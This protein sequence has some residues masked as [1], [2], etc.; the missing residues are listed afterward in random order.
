MQ[1]QAFAALKRANSFESSKERCVTQRGARMR[2]LVRIHVFLCLRNHLKSPNAYRLNPSFQN[3]CRGES[4]WF[5][6]E[7]S[8]PFS[9][10]SFFHARRLIY[11]AAHR[12][13]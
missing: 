9:F 2:F 11:A 8:S 1:T 6:F 7:R 13:S 5:A 12:G 3:K 4:M 10:L